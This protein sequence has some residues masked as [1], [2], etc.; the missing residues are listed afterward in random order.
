[1]HVSDRAQHS[2]PVRQL[3]GSSY[4]VNVS[5]SVGSV[6]ARAGGGSC[7]CD[8]AHFASR[9]VAESRGEEVAFDAPLEQSALQRTHRHLHRNWVQF[10]KAPIW[11]AQFLCASKNG[12]TL[13]S[14]VT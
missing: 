14:H 1:M 6:C 9:K 8:V 4:K 13:V 5:E 3:F 10:L 11:Q 12:P 7:L 2:D